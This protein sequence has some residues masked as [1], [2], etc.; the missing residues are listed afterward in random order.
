[1]RYSTKI[2]VS[3]PARTVW[4]VLHDAEDWPELTPSM[5]RVDLLDGPLGP[6][7]RIRIEQPGLRPMTWAVT[8]Y[9]DG[10]SFTYL[11]TSPGV[12]VSAWH[13]VDTD[14][15]GAH[16]TL[17]VEMRGPLAWLIGTLVGARTRSYVDQEAAGIKAA[18]ERNRP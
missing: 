13:R 16:L 9:V 8:E 14:R 2:P 7:R 10:E 6:G 11:A 5:A 3:A 4:R 18:A 12:R 1:M 15:D 17:G